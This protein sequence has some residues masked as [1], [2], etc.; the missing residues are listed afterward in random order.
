MTIYYLVIL[1]IIFV[2]SSGVH[3]VFAE[4]EPIITIQMNGPSTFY[5]DESNQIIRAS[6]E[7]QNYTPS[8]GIYF[9]KV[10]YLSTQKV[11]KDFEIYP[12]QSGNDMWSV[13]IAYPFL[14]S[15]IQVGNQ[16][17][18]G[19]YEIL[20]RTENGSQTASTGFSILETAT[21]SNT[22]Q[23]SKPEP[24]P[25]IKPAPDTSALT[26]RI[27]PGAVLHD[28]AA[29]V[30]RWRHPC[31]DPYEITI[32]VDEEVKWTIGNSGDWDILSGHAST[33][34]TGFFDSGK[35]NATYPYSFK[36]EEE[37]IFPYYSTLRPWI[38]GTVIV[39]NDFSL[40]DQIPDWLKNMVSQWGISHY[41]ES[42]FLRAIGYLIER[43]FIQSEK[44]PYD[45]S[46]VQAASWIRTVAVWWGEGL[47]TDEEFVNTMQNLIDR[48]II[49]I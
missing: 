47:I 39:G 20:I 48:E 45:Y 38:T 30:E 41:Q 17:L 32:V 25:E 40:D 35:F 14:E 46:E 18:F 9:M 42:E 12:K 21:E 7:I 49:K 24:T 28:C 13:Q 2:F 27:E 8:D 11:M 10:T 4:N 19:E 6:V 36:F 43:D 1:G 22:Q 33:G 29:G 44:I 31:V 23:I 15:D 34:P 3:Y 5:L 37:G 26:V 16:T